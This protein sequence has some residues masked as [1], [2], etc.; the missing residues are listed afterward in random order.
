MVLLQSTIF[1]KYVD[2]HCM[3]SFITNNEIILQQFTSDS[4]QRV[5]QH[6]K[7]ASTRLPKRKKHKNHN[8]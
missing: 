5:K 1:N 3:I 2:E 8:L 6:A 4:D 7:H